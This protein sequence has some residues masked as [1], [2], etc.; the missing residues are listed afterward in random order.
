MEKGMKESYIERPSK[1]RWP[2]VMRRRPVRARRSVHRGARGPA[3][4]PRNATFR[5]ADTFLFV[6]GSTVGRDIAS[7]RRA[8]R[9]LRTRARVRSFHAENRE[10]WWSPAPFDDAPSWMVRGVAY[11][12]VAGRGGNAQAVIPR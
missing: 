3:I 12:L 2:R 8:L 10:I 5:G 1:S 11:R 9:G 6:E 4:E 7:G